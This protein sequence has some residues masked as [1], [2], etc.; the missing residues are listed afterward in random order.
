MATKTGG[1]STKT[2][3]SQND[4]ATTKMPLNT[5]STIPTPREDATQIVA[6][7]RHS[8]K[9]S[10]Y[11]LSDG[12]IVDKSEGVELAKQGWI[13]GVGVAQRSG[14]EYLKSLPDVEPDNNLASLPTVSEEE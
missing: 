1:S 13:E 6:V 10:G 11:Q 7:V 3:K 5:F 14:M 9:I 12:R 2:Y 4:Y 8:G